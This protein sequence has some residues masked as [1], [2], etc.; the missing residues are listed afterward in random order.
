MEFSPLTAVSP[1]DGRYRRAC[2]GLSGYFS[3]GALIRY[4]TRVEVEYFIALCGLPLPQLKDVDKSVLGESSQVAA[5]LEGRYPCLEVKIEPNEI[6][7]PGVYLH[8]A[9]GWCQLDLF[10][11]TFIEAHHPTSDPEYVIELVCSHMRRYLQGITVVRYHARNGKLV[12]WEG[13]WGIDPAVR[14]KAVAGGRG[15]SFLRKIASRE[16]KSFKFITAPNK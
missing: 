6:D 8:A 13:Y 10:G 4:R 12:K 15:F 16:E 14:T 2:A 3:E 11:A 7:I 5:H 9:R 1:I